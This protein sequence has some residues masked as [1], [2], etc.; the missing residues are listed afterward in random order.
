MSKNLILLHSNS[1]S[2]NLI[3]TA[4]QLKVFPEFDILIIDNDPMESSKEIL[5]EN[6]QIKCIIYDS[7]TEFG[8]SLLSA[9]EYSRD[10]DYE[11]LITIDTDNAGYLKDIPLIIENIK[12]DFDII[13]LSRILENFSHK[14]IP[15]KYLQDTELIAAALIEITD[16][17][18]TDPLSETKCYRIKSV[19]LMELSEDTHT[20]LLQIWIQAAH[21]GMSVIEIPSNSGETFGKEIDMY[22]NLLLESLAFMETEKY[23]Y[24]RERIN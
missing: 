9:F 10:L 13:S 18:I 17:D 4:L 7:P 22:E 21:F 11:Y 12:Y 14:S 15:E 24:P 8:T 20:I 23:L 19:L 3:K 1:N 2:K 5:A 6:P 16:I